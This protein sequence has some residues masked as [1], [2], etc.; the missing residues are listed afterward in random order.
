[1]N[2]WRTTLAG[3]ANQ[4]KDMK[5]GKVFCAAMLRALPPCRAPARC[6][7]AV[8]FAQRGNAPRL[9]A[10]TAFSA[11][12]NMSIVA[13]RIQNNDMARQSRPDEQRAAQTKPADITAIFRLNQ[14]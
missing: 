6:R 9:F 5:G 8:L 7:A 13:R 4:R 14:S 12:R 3:T 2:E 1:M 11:Q 10:A